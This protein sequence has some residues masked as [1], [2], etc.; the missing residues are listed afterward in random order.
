MS[1]RSQDVALIVRVPFAECFLHLDIQ[2]VQ[3]VGLHQ[4]G[5]GQP[6]EGPPSVYRTFLACPEVLSRSGTPRIQHE[7]PSSPCCLLV[8]NNKGESKGERK[9]VYH[10]YEGGN[11][12]GALLPAS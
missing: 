7:A 5:V 6:G 11:R 3:R 2:V 12:N 4:S 1:G 9:K 10:E 8:N